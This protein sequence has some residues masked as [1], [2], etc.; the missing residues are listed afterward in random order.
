MKWL[1]NSKFTMWICV[2]GAGL[3]TFG[4]FMLGD[5]LRIMAAV[6][7]AIAALGWYSTDKLKKESK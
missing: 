4:F 2:A 7:A 6:W 1:N 3:N 5:E